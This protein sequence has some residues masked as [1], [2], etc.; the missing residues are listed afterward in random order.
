MGMVVLRIMLR[1][2]EYRDREPM[3]GIWDVR[4]EGGLMLRSEEKRGEVRRG[5]GR[6]ER[7]RCEGEWRERLNG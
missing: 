3:H 7:P 6:E 5:E 1:S 4:V 2:T